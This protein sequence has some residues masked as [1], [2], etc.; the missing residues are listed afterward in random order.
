M[1]ICGIP[2]SEA[3]IPIL[4]PPAKGAVPAKFTTKVVDKIDDYYDNN[5][6]DNDNDNCNV[7]DHYTNKSEGKNNT[8]IVILA[9]GGGMAQVNLGQKLLKC[10]IFRVFA[11][12]KNRDPHATL[13]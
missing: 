11:V 7:D 9:L 13:S 12:S 4:D 2:V 6:N 10:L 8:T 5:D 1:E 3:E